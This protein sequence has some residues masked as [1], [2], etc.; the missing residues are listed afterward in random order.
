LRHRP[1]RDLVFGHGAGPFAGFAKAKKALENKLVAAV[2][3]WTPHDFRRSLSTALHERFDL[4]P[5]I[6][7]TILGHVGGYN[8][9][10]AASTTN[11]FIW[12]SAA[13]RSSARVTQQCRSD[14]GRG[15]LTGK[16][17]I[18]L[19]LRSL[20]HF[21]HQRR[22]CGPCMRVFSFHPAVPINYFHQFL[23]RLP[24]IRGAASLGS[25]HQQLTNAK[26]VRF[27]E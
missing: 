18:G 22:A 20:P 24:D 5:H 16:T 8:R 27:L 13:M 15:C 12:T 17:P 26:P 6:V 11:Q 19:L 10:S 7:E 2:A 25:Q 1:D 3:P 23:R 14:W 9:A 21:I 4:P